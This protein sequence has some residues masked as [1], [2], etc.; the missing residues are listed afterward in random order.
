MPY[1][2]F[3][4]SQYLQAHC[5]IEGVPRNVSTGAYEPSVPT[6]ANAAQLLTLACEYAWQDWSNWMLLPSITES[7]SV[8]PNGSHV[9]AWADLQNSSKWSLWTIDPRTS[10]EAG[11]GLWDS[12]RRKGVQHADGVLVVD[13]P[14]AAMVAFYQKAAPKFTHVNV[15]SATTYATGDLVWDGTDGTITTP[16]TGH[17]YLALG[18]HAGSTIADTTKWRKQSA[19]EELRQAIMRRVNELR[20]GYQAR[21]P[22]AAQQEGL[23]AEAMLEEIFQRHS[24]TLPPWFTMNGGL[25]F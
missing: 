8:T 7:A 12:Y 3:S 18:A 1:P 14:E 16:A 25:K 21:Q 10:Y 24:R 5:L 13:D 15:V 2:Q 22:Q 11:D 6:K 9:I 19:P 23:T 4:F 17:C 20:Q